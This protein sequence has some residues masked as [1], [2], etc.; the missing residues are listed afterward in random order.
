MSLDRMVDNW[1]HIDIKFLGFK[2][3]SDKTVVG[4]QVIWYQGAKH[5]MCLHMF[6]RGYA[7]HEYKLNLCI[8]FVQTIVKCQ[9]LKFVW[10]TVQ[11]CF[12]KMLRSLDVTF[13]KTGRVKPHS[14]YYRWVAF[15]ICV[16]LN[17]QISPSILGEEQLV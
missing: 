10:A 9:V 4:I 2:W 8:L 15:S 3:K 1:P 17:L 16:R 5:M 12:H 14:V 6:H 11:L 7:L 13:P